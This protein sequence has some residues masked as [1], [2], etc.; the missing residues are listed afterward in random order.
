MIERSPADWPVWE[1]HPQGDEPVLVLSGRAVF[2]QALDAGDQHIEDGAG[3]ALVNPA[4]VW[5][6]ADV[7]E[8]LTALYL[9]PC[10]GT[11]HRAR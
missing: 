10:P 7:H 2:I 5:H 9:T 4:G 1:C 11:E 6:T 3:E 8:P